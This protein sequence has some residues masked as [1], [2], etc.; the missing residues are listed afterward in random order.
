VAVSKAKRGGATLA[1]VAEA[2][3]VSKMTASRVLR[4][5][6]GFS[7]DTRERVMREVVRLGYVPNRIAATFGS[8]QL[9]TLVGV[10]VPRLTSDLFGSVLDS[11]DH[12]LSKFG[13]QTMIGTHEQSPETEENWLR[14]ILAWRPA[15]VILSGRT[16][17]R[18]TIEVL[19]AHSIPVVE[20][21]NLNTSP[22]DV[23]V[24]FNH[25]DCGFE[26]GNYFISQSHQNIAYVGAEANAAGMGVV[27]LEGF[28]KAL[29][30]AGYAF[31]TKEILADK[32]SFYAGF[33]G[34]EN[35][36]NRT[37]EVDAIYFQ[38]DTM[39]VGGLFYC[40]SKG[41]SI[42]NDI[43]IAGWGGMEIASVL[44]ERL[45]TTAVTTQAL[46]KTAAEAL[47]A[48]IRGEPTQDVTVASTRLVPGNTV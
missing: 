43:G 20:V 1:E 45:T 11:I 2:A 37:S 47:V 48:R 42:P 10:S 22:L 40:K 26:M 28:E 41:L 32:P 34:T 5:A 39:A 23:S 44:P 3:G 18:G 17:T 6:T 4:N 13:Y 16:H 35:V 29:H 9:S 7:P 14:A 8:D 38:N 46:G 36:L 15:G 19:R 31:I 30:N 25:F 27:R 21:W 33:Y 24:G 12:S